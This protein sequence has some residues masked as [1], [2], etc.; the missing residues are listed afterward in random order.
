MKNVFSSVFIAA[1]VLFSSTSFAQKFYLGV[2]GGYGFKFGSQTT[3]VGSSTYD[4]INYESSEKTEAVNYSLGS[5]INFGANLGYMFNKNIG[6]DLGINYLVGTNTSLEY[7]STYIGNLYT[8]VRTA[9][10][11]ISANMLR[12]IPTMVISASLEGLNPY[13][14]FGA[15]VGMLGTIKSEEET[16]ETDQGVTT[17]TVVESKEKG[18]VSIGFTGAIG[19]EYG[20]SDKISL[21]GEINLIGMSYAPTKGEYTKY[22]IDGVDQ[23][24]NMSTSEKEWVNEKEV[25][26]DSNDQ[27]DDSKPSEELKINN[28]MSSVGLSIGVKFS[29]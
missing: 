23:L 26:Y 8:D 21:F 17:V 1:C 28:P 16:N 14:K 4:N 2:N 6:V 7:T 10:L 13:A 25:S 19:A 20:L 12:L 15:V 18:G 11:S 29:F 9:N 22:T 27:P 5:G 24:A 3:Y